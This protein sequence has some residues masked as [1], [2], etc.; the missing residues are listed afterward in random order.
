MKYDEKSE[1]PKSVGLTGLY[2]I[3]ALCLVVVGAIAWF[4]VARRSGD[5]TKISEGDTTSPKNSYSSKY[6]SYNNDEDDLIPDT[7]STAKDKDDVPYEET[8]KEETPAAIPQSFIMPVDGAVIK[9]HSETALQFSKT[10]G[11]MRLHLG[12]DIKCEKNSNIKAVSNGTVTDVT[13]SALYG[14]T[15]VIDHGNGITAKYCGL[16][17]T[18]V[19]SGDKV[20]SSTIIGIIGTVPSECADEI[21][22]HF[23]VYKN[24]KLVSP[25]KTLGFE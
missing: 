4:A 6:S 7:E 21:H 8:E 13:E 24:G 20:D 25:L 23:E 1:F 18:E 5:K 16:S 2:T 19:K 17:K 10:Y 14:K 3:I 9:D 22:L 15:V 11:D 12:I